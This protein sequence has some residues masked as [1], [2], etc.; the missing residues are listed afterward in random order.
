MQELL[1]IQNAGAHLQ[2]ALWPAVSSLSATAASSSSNSTRSSVDT[3]S[4]VVT[5]EDVVLFKYR[6]EKSG[7][8][9]KAEATRA[10]LSVCSTPEVCTDYIQWCATGPRMDLFVGS[11]GGKELHSTNEETWT[12]RPGLNDLCD[13]A[14]CERHY[15]INHAGT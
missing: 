9:D 2:Q 1:C 12:C 10:L 14:S 6:L 4:S 8:E 13:S 15:F 11:S 5:F 7:K 3:A